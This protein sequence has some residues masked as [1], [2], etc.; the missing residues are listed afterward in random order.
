MDWL[1]ILIRTI[2]DWLRELPPDLLGRKVEQFLDRSPEHRRKL[3][4][5]RGRGPWK[6]RKRAARKN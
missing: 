1:E 2:G 5:S 4:K 3:R 6:H